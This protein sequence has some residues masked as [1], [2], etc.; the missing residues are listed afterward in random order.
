MCR[1]EYLAADHNAVPDEIRP[2][3][4]K[5]RSEHPRYSNSPVTTA[6]RAPTRWSIQRST[7]DALRQRIVFDRLDIFGGG[8]SF[9]VR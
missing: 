2:L 4:K 3:L 9:T 7:R 1:R 8:G 5:E 6:Q